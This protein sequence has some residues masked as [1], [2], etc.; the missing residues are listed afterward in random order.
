MDIDGKLKNLRETIPFYSWL[1]PVNRESEQKKFFNSKKYNPVYQYKINLTLIKNVTLKID[2]IKIPDSPFKYFYRQEIEEIKIMLKMLTGT[3]KPV[4]FSK[5][6]QKI[7][8]SYSE[9]DLKFA[10]NFLRK[11]QDPTGTEEISPEDIQKILQQEINESGISG[12]QIILKKDIAS[13]VTVKPLVK[14]IF[15]KK[16]YSFYPGEGRRLKIHEIQVHLFRAEN[17]D[18]QKAGIFKRGLPG[19][20]EA[21]EGLAVFYE[22][23]YGKIYDKNYRR[24]CL[25]QMKVYAGRLKA[26]DL[27]LKNS[28]REVY[29]K[30]KKWFAPKMAYRLTE[31]A[32][33]GLHRTAQPG[34]LTK[35]VHY[36]TGYRKIKNNLSK[37]RIREVLFTG[38]IGLKDIESS[39]R[40]L[41]QNILVPPRYQPGIKF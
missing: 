22:N 39:D 35:D 37:K 8:G 2:R 23:K 6:S 36:I 41:R 9:S 28:F 14:K 18:R 24:E 30:L 31:R 16:D 38:K 32:K 17:G 4:Q 25:R 34:A 1:T 10:E 7:Y 20:M 27:A 40:L 26:V 12:W 33:R 15:I 29:Q 19:Y 3:K 5:L 13:K 11:N 21:E